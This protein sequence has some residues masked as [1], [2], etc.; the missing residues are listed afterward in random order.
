MDLRDREKEKNRT[1]YIVM[2]GALVCFAY[3]A[4]MISTRDTLS[5]DTAVRYWVYG[6]RNPILSK[7]FI[8]ITYM[9]NWQS[10]T[11]LALVLLAVPKTRK[12]IGLPFAVISLASTVCYKLVK[13]CFQRPRPDLAVRIIEQGGYSFPSGHSM[14]GLVCFGILIYL[15][16]RYC[17]NRKTA[18]VLTAFLALLIVLIGC[19]RVYV[20]V[21][22]PTDILGGWSL[23]LFCL[24]AVIL[25]LEKI[26]GNRKW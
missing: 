6:L 22:F 10:I 26:R 4:Y 5:F 23:G 12:N 15:I 9:G 16:R 19:S 13:E 3:I 1:R 14:N 24:M 18:N 25:I 2:G 20:G 17:P 8:T 21:H 11:L 7:I